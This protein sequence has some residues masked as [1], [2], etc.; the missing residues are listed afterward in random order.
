[1]AK[2]FEAPGASD[3]VSDAALAG[4]VTL[5]LPTVGGHFSVT[6]T[7]NASGAT[8]SI[9]WFDRSE[10]RYVLSVGVD[11]GATFP[12]KLPERLDRLMLSAMSERERKKQLEFRNVRELVVSAS[13]IA[14]ISERLERPEIRK[15]GNET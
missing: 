11:T 2:G 6:L 3:V 10:E 7:Q 8:L 9:R 13:D 14:A 4:S 12:E 15:S 5:R 1:M